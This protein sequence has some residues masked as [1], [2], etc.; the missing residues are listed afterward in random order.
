[1]AHVNLSSISKHFDSTV[2]VD[3]LSL[4]AQNGEFVSLLGPSGCGK[5]TTLRMIAGFIEPT[6][7]SIEIGGNIF[8]EPEKRIFIPPERRKLGMVFQSYAV[9]PHMNVFKN[10]AY[11]LRVRKFA[12]SEI[13]KRVSKVA[14][15]VKM[16]ELLARYPSQLSGGQQQR[17][18]LARALVAEPRV[19]LLDEP[20]SNL[21]A[22]LREEMRLE[23]KELQRRLGITIIFVTHDQEE[24][25]VLSDRIAVMKDGRILQVGAPRDIYEKPADEFVARF[26]GAANMLPIEAETGHVVNDPEFILPVD[27]RTGFAV[28]RPEDVEVRQE[29]CSGFVSMEV[30]TSMFLGDEVL[31]F[32]KRKEQKVVVKLRR[33]MNPER[34]ETLFIRVTAA[35]VVRSGEV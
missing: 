7:G 28:V 31:C 27:G 2:A 25:M 14:E 32:L 20:L 6:A 29:S 26:I 5:T 30:Q 17:V 8:S 34:G 18:A 12:K 15:Q 16:P 9:W 1:M 11:P 4:E 35:A 10:I 3:H 19:L 21:D 33:S 22:K 13:K 24:A 23:I